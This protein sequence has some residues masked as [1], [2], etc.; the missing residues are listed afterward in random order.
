M[1]PMPHLVVLP[2]LLP[3]VTAL[4][5][6]LLGG[7][8]R[9]SHR[10]LGTIATLVTFLLAAIL[11]ARTGAG[12]VL[13]YRP[14]A[15]PAPF[16]IVLVADRL[17]A[18]MLLLTGT[19][20][21]GAL[22]YAMNGGDSQGRHFHAFFQLQLAGI[23]G[24]FLTGDLFNLFVFFEILLIASYC[25]LVFGGGAARAKAGVHYVVLNL[26]GSALFLIAIGTLYGI[27]GALNMAHLS[28]RIAELPMA[29][30]AIV[31]AA[32]LLLIIVFA[33]K[34]AA[35][36]F[37]FWLPG[38]YSSA[39]ASVAALF[40]IM[41]KVGVYAIARI[42]TLM[43]GP[44]AGAGA[45]LMLPWLLPVAIATCVLGFAGALASAHLR[46][47]LGFLL[48]ASVG[49]I[50]IGLGMFS[51]SGIGGA[52]YYMVHST[53]TFA[54]LF[55]IADLIVR[56]RGVQGDA[57]STANPVAEPGRLGALFFLGA[58]AVVG[59]PPLAGFLGKALILTAIPASGLGTAAWV[60]ILTG[61]LIALVAL[62]RAGIALF[63]NTD[64]ARP[65]AE[66]GSGRRLVPAAA[67]VLV[68]AAIVIASGPLQSFTSA[69]A[70]QLL[71][72]QAYVTTVL[73][74]GAP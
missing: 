57:L 40:A 56:Q 7:E 74:E 41:T 9:R 47:M 61:S 24:A 48:I 39:T 19:V 20:A 45:D 18:M 4:A 32:G 44:E 3:F 13:V 49:T 25:L 43:F 1:N 64:A 30:A 31:R 23:H 27:T 66:A 35:A 60:V 70:E 36:P 34:A 42:A 38:A 8:L 11:V 15:W 59:L 52:L 68:L 14:G 63:W 58:I 46:V 72:P 21:L 5:C 62:T 28:V 71:T 33:L 54:A 50:L 17:A 73:G 26:V 37:Y 55:L 51:W 22:L 69:A 16:G 6:V 2:I 29:D 12:E 53:L 65:A 10:A 67:L